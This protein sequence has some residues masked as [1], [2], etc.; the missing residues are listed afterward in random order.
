MGAATATPGHTG[1]TVWGSGGH[2]LNR[3]RSLSRYLSAAALPKE[4]ARRRQRSRGG[5][6]KAH[7]QGRADMQRPRRVL[8][9]CGC[10]R[11][12]PRR[13]NWILQRRVVQQGSSSS[14][15]GGNHVCG[16]LRWPCDRQAKHDPFAHGRRRTRGRAPH[17]GQGALRRAAKRQQACRNHARQRDQQLCVGLPRQHCSSRGIRPHAPGRV[18]PCRGASAVVAAP[19][20]RRRRRGGGRRGCTAVML[21]P[22]P[23]PRVRRGAAR[24]RVRV[25]RRPGWGWGHEVLWRGRATAFWRRALSGPADI[26]SPALARLVGWCRRRAL[27]LRPRPRRT[28]AVGAGYEVS[29]SPCRT[30]R[31]GEHLSPPAR[32]A[33]AGG[34]HG[35]RPWTPRVRRWRLLHRERVEIRR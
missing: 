13:F 35:T 32:R 15:R 8:L 28:H 4:R 19:Q 18:P 17:E 20:Q 25:Q 24:A 34:V 7:G 21:R 9:A 26:H 27:A 14:R 30:R 3:F 29:R 22:N 12:V 16:R 31:A 6:I 10:S 11:C 1:G 23:P 2:V 33:S 5:G